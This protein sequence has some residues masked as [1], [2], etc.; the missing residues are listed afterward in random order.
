MDLGEVLFLIDIFDV[1]N[2]FKVDVVVEF[3][4]GYEIVKELVFVVICN[5]KYVVIVNKVLIVVYGN[6][7]FEVV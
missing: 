3:I 7:I 5:G 1:V 4:G 2:D 6:E